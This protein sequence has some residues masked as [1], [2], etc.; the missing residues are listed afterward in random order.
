MAKKETKTLKFKCPACGCEKLEEV[1]VGVR[2]LSL[3]TAIDESG[4]I[5][6]DPNG[7]NAEE[8]EVSNYQCFNCGEHLQD[9]SGVV[10][11]PDILVEWLKK[12]CPQE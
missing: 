8:G 7:V 1:L 6:Y 3:I 11:D 9:E 4:A 5:D 2:Q 10:N 12:N